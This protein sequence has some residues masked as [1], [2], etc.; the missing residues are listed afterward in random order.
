[1]K[2]PTIIKI[3]L[4]EILLLFCSISLAQNNSGALT[5][6][7][8]EQR[9]N[10][11]IK[12]LEEKIRDV[13]K[14]Y[15]EFKSKPIPEKDGELIPYR[16]NWE[17]EKYY[18]ESSIRDLEN[19][20]EA[21]RNRK[22]VE[23]NEAI[24][25]EK[26][27]QQQK[28][29]EQLA[30]QAADK[31]AK[32]AADKAAKEAAE[33]AAR[34]AEAKRLKELERQK[35]EARLAAEHQANIEQAKAESEAK[36]AQLKQKAQW[37]ASEERID[38]MFDMMDSNLRPLELPGPARRPPEE[39]RSSALDILRLKVGLDQPEEEEPQAPKRTPKECYEAFLG[40][41]DL[42]PEELELV[43]QYN[44]SLPPIQ[45]ASHSSPSSSPSSSPRKPNNK[46]Q[47]GS[48]D[49]KNTDYN[50][51]VDNTYYLPILPEEI[52]PSF[53]NA[54]EPL[55]VLSPIEYAFASQEEQGFC[56]LPK[57]GVYALKNHTLVP[58]SQLNG[59]KYPV[60]RDIEKVLSSDNQI[61]L[62]SKSAIW[63]F[64]SFKARYLTKIGGEEC[65]L[66]TGSNGQIFK[67][68]PKGSITEVQHWD[69]KQKR[70]V[71]L[72]SF[73]GEAEKVTSTQDGVV[74]ALH[75]DCI[76]RLEEAQWKK[77]YE[78]KDDVIND[79]LAI[80]KDLLAIDNQAVRKVYGENSGDILYEQGGRQIFY[81]GTE[82]FII[83]NNQIYSLSFQINQ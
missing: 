5:V 61:L 41:E 16:S 82:L 63:D 4:I 58:I 38:Q 70:F 11:R 75:G 77:M 29:D 65:D 9:H 2:Y 15:E 62:L 14:G 69:A 48:F 42:T 54:S 64:S 19:R 47:S 43:D 23:V 81:D 56:I 78:N 50:V 44:L 10:D 13:R 6:R 27:R 18:Y 26:I 79:I 24:I 32:E 40:G 39:R 60:A 1:M 72:A 35:E 55:M 8:I 49:K 83:D 21:E 59:R 12:E 68:M 20:I 67:T 53:N 22:D 30:K 71:P 45:S 52:S 28:R 33:K 57:K 46:N 80:D 17:N 34:E 74:F 7:E 66:F 37:L 31:A 73:P 76:Y 51:G 3:S 36:Y 25:A